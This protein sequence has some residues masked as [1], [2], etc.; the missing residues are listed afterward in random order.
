M[1]REALEGART[2]GGRKNGVRGGRLHTMMV[3]VQV[4]FHKQALH[5]GVNA[6]VPALR[7]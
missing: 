1:S 4:S 6:S 2:K 5:D 3:L 7:G